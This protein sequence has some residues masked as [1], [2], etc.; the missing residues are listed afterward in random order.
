MPA[1]KDDLFEVALATEHLKSYRVRA[2]R[3]R[4]LPGPRRPGRAG[5]GISGAMSASV[6]AAS[7]REG[8]CVR[9]MSGL[10]EISPVWVSEGD[11]NP[12]AGDS[13]PEW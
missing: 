5:G 4:P 2:G 8:P 9:V 12:H 6:M 10:R 3:H 1:E 13:S 11:L 7:R